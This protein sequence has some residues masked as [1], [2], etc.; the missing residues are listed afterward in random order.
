MPSASDSLNRWLGD[1]QLRRQAHGLQRNRLEVSNRAGCTVLVDGQK[2][3]NFSSN[4]YLGLAADPALADAL[5][6]A[7]AQHGAGS[8]ASALVSGFSSVHRQLEQQLADFLG[9]EAALLFPSGYQANLAIH[10]AL[11]A[12]GDCIVQDR[13]CHASLIDGARLSGARLLRY[14]HVDISA[15]DRQLERST[16]EHTLVVT[17]GVFSMDGDI[18]PLPELVEVCERHGAWLAVDDAH[19]VGVLG[20]GGQGS[21]SHLG[22]A[23]SCVPVLVGTLGKAFGVSGAY[24]AGSAKLVDHLLNHARSYLY[25]TAMPPPLAAAGLAALQVIRNGKAQRQLLHDRIGYFKN[26][27]AERGLVLLPSETPIQPLLIGEAP[28][29]LRV[30]QQLRDLGF[31][32]VAIRPPTVPQGSSRLRITLSAVHEEEQIDQLL[33]GL[34]TCMNNR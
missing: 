30:S 25:T 23:A 16:A 22:V 10:T 7:C 33:D 15:L 34:L 27:A 24:V 28:A 11:A 32:V 18:A 5:S 4:D 1:E 3:I 6:Q 20:Q 12:R 17:D 29:A 13:L 8:G 31:L 21:L 14:P 19:G 2:L 9:T 26:G